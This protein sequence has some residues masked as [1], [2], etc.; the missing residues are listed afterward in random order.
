MLRILGV[1]CSAPSIRTG[2][3]IDQ[4]DRPTAVGCRIP[5]CK[6][7]GDPSQIE[8]VGDAE[9]RIEAPGRPCITR[10]S[11]GRSCCCLHSWGF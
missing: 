11:A 7:R 10:R 9:V 5:F 6:I 1:L 2:L 4:I 3:Q 8:L